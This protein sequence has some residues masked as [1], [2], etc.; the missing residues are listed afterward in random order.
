MNDSDHQGWQRS[1]PGVK[2]EEG[3]MFK[4]F[5]KRSEATEAQ[6]PDQPEELQLNQRPLR[7][8]ERLVGWVYGLSDD[9]LQPSSSLRA[10]QRLLGIIAGLLII[11]GII[12]CG[13]AAYAASLYVSTPQALV[14][15][16]VWAVIIL[17]MDR[18]LLATS[19]HG[20]SPWGIGARVLLSCL[21]SVVVSIPLELYLF[22]DYLDNL[23]AEETLQRQLQAEK[24]DLEDSALLGEGDPVYVQLN[25]QLQ[26]LREQTPHLLQ[27]KLRAEER[28][29][30]LNDILRRE[31]E[32]G[33]YGK[34]SER[35]DEQL[36]EHRERVH[37]PA[38]SAWSR[39]QAQ[40]EALEK[41]LQESADQRAKAREDARAQRKS[42]RQDI[43]QTH[44][45]DLVTRLDELDRA[46][47]RSV[48]ILWFKWLLR[49]L[50]VAIELMPLLV[51]IM[52]RNQFK[53]IQG[54]LHQKSA[55]LLLRQHREKELD[56]ALFARL[57]KSRQWRAQTGL[58]EADL[59]FAEDTLRRLSRQDLYELPP[60]VRDEFERAMLAS[61]IQLFA[62]RQQPPAQGEPHQASA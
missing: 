57:N 6:A 46:E 7:L 15:G 23:H 61:L 45:R 34:R 9:L 56:E 3:A 47:A 20:S 49:M 29:H 51:K 50:L 35:K 41:E 4:F 11:P 5:Q 48:H 28:L 18:A 43:I 16:A 38:V 22:S 62:D 36:I 30:E 33:G 27:Q 60:H 19:L 25:E 39:N 44:Q 8:R 10:E 52:T 26:R 31:M 58:L 1:L 55:R 2:D 32:D 13:A 17:L 12:S 40:I 14:V 42:A 24:E 59:S 21:I 37:G 54:V 53:T